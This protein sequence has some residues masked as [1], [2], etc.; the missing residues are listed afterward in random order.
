[1]TN[2]GASLGT[3]LAGSVMIAA[4][5]SAFLTDIKQGPA[6]PASVKSEA[7]VKLASGVP[8]VSDAD[9]Q[10][11]LEG[12]NVDQQAADA[13]L[14]AYRNARIS[15]LTSSL[16]LLASVALSGLFLAQRIPPEPAT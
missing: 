14:E 1:M 3:A 9:L 15:G 2:L 11:A 6:I 13:A 16:A 7:Q 4:V 8:F 10:Q 5:T 12:A